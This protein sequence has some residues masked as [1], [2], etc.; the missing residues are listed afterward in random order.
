MFS[1][2]S[3]LSNQQPNFYNGVA[4]QSLR[5]DSASSASLEKTFGTADDDDKLIFSFWAKRSTPSANHKML[6]KYASTDNRFYIG[7]ADNDKL[8]IYQKVGG[9]ESFNLQTNRLFRDPSAW[10]HIVVAFDTTQGTDTNKIK[11]YV[12]GT[13]ETS[14]STS[15]YPIQNL[16][17]YYQTATGVV[18]YIGEY[19]SSQYFDGYL[20]EVNLVDGL[21]F[22]S[23]TSGTPNPS[24]NINSFGE[25]KNGV[26]IPKAYSGSYGTNGFRLQ[27]NK[28]G[29][30][31]GSTTTVG[32]D[33]SG[34]LN[35]WDTN[36]VDTEDCDMP[37]SPENNFAT[38]CP[39]SSEV[40]GTFSEGNLKYYSN[41]DS[42]N[43]NQAISSGNFY[44]EVY[45]SGGSNSYV[46]VIDV[47]QGL[48]PNRGGSFA[49]NGGIFYKQNGDQY[50]RAI[51]ASAVTASYG[52]T[53]TSGDIIG[54]AV[55]VDADTITF[56]KNG[57]SQGTTTNGVSYINPNGLYTFMVYGTG[58][59]YT[60]NFGQDPSFAGT[61]TGGDI[62]TETPSQGAGVFKH[63]VP[64]GYK[65]LCTANISDDD[66][67]ISPAQS[68]Q[69]D[70]YFSPTLYTSDDIG[71]GGTQSITDVGFQPDWVWI[72][73]KSSDGTSHTLFDSVRLAGKMLQ[74]DNDSLEASNSQYGY[75]S[76]FDSDGSGGGGFTLTGGTTNANF[77]NQGTD[78]YVSWNWKAGGTAVT[79][80][81]G[82]IQTQV[83][84]NTDA[85]FSIITYSGS[86]T[87][88]DTIGHGLNSAP[89]CIHWKRRNATG[90]WMAYFEVLGTG[91]YLN[92]DRTNGFDTGASPVN[93]VAP[94]N[95]VITLS[96]LGT[97]NNSAGTYVCY[98]FHDVDGYSKFGSYTGN[99]S[100]DGN[101]IFLGFRPSFVIIKY[102]SGTAGGTK[103]WFMFDDA[104]DTFNPTDDTINANASD[105]ETA[106]S[107]KDIDF[108]S[109]GFKIRNAEGAINNAA[110]YIYMAWAST[111]FKYANAR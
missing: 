41:N 25:L 33:T 77:I 13:E 26:W 56:Y 57:V 97:I 10:Y 75:L 22:F 47:T 86:G 99:D 74:S 39:L 31:T 107:N 50:S 9:T 81:Q 68:T 95:S 18:A 30:G 6:V 88:G 82:D 20:A 46:G 104:R 52:A 62:G 58:V 73:N 96:S 102:A 2:E 44:A 105:G 1:S 12:N 110:E 54:I 89:T 17:L 51:N 76:S 106:D 85:G 43:A 59:T 37:D 27:F 15:N 48:N 32:A 90:N 11:L 78:D 29:T 5:F 92:L 80:T 67:P 66:L 98:A 84:A 69:A 87:A 40:S 21:S 53:Y 61:L 101:F 3:W 19:D 100:T 103:N 65:A 55:D 79:N 111:P 7:F 14:F 8:Y 34:N 16:D 35:H 45:V 36:A 63:A 72:K 24:F 83:S 64:S 91:G 23:D 109:N 94:T 42:G 60:V 28:T 108:L 4:T 49:D 70:D 71:A 93:G 38:I